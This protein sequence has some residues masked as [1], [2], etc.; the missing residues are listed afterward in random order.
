MNRSHRYPVLKRAREITHTADLD[1]LEIRKY[2]GAPLAMDIRD[3][4]VGCPSHQ[5][6]IL[7]FQEVRAVTA[8]VSEELGPLL[9][10]TVE[11]TPALEHRYP[12]L[13]LWEPEHAY[14]FAMA[15]TNSGGAGLAILNKPVDQGPS[16]LEISQSGPD[17]FVVLGQLSGQ[18]VQILKLA[19]E[20][21]KRGQWLTSEALEELSFLASVS[22]AARSKR[23]TELYAR[24]LLA[25]RE[26]PHN[27]KSRWFRPPWRL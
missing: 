9:M 6:L 11:K 23:L 21:A 18:M 13:G 14:T 27:P 5:P 22:P 19:D 16:L 7:D 25:Y 26:N 20:Y 3:W 10:Q 12:I 8:S 4:L 24:R 2:V 17:R 1:I 15:F